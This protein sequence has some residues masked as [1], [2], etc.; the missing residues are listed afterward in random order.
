[1][2]ELCGFGGIVQF[3]HPA[4]CQKVCLDQIKFLQLFSYYTYLLAKL[5]TRV[6][7]GLY[8]ANLDMFNTYS[9][10]VKKNKKKKNYLL[11]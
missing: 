2:R 10:N 1:M 9:C 7:L 3:L 8:C 5:N 4:P 6:G 11:E